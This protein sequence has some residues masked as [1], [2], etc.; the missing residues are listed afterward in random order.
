MPRLRF[1]IASLC[2]LVLAR[3][4]GFSAQKASQKAASD[5]DYSKEAF[6]ITSTQ[7]H[8]RFS[9]DGSSIRMQTTSVKVL[10]EAGV[11][12]WGV[13]EF[14]FASDNEHVDVH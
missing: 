2:L 3:T 13:L 6:V 12:D 14:P 10:S 1:L 9:S 8:V 7:T 4:Y 5:P 11:E